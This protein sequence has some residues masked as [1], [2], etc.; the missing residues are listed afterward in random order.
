MIHG[1]GGSTGVLHKG[2]EPRGGW[3]ATPP[4][5]SSSQPA[6][7]PLFP[8]QWRRG[9]AEL[10]SGVDDIQ[11]GGEGLGRRS[12]WWA[13]SEGNVWEESGNVEED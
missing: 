12:R 9:I 3:D 8:W 7:V 1:F 11:D 6:V 5:S 4:D 10:Q 13:E 2:E